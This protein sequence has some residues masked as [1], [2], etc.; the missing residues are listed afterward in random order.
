MFH[1]FYLKTKEIE[2]QWHYFLKQPKIEI[3]KK[4]DDNLLPLYFRF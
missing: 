3:K 1:L 4:T 2:I